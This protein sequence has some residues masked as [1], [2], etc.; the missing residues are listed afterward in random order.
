[1]QTGKRVLWFLIAAL[2]AVSL[3]VIATARRA[4]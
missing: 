1:M 2:G 3:G 4:E